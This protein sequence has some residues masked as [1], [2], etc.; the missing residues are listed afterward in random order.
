MRRLIRLA[1]VAA[2]VAMQGF[3]PGTASAQPAAIGSAQS[4]QLGNGI[5]HVINIA[6][7]GAVKDLRAGRGVEPT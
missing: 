1:V 4:C 3:V 5:K 7:V 6:E 2:V